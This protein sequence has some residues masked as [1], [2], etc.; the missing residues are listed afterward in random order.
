MTISFLYGMALEEDSRRWR[1]AKR[2]AA[3]PN[4]SATTIRET[5][6]LFYKLPVL[7]TPM[8]L[9]ADNENTRTDLMVKGLL[10]TMLKIMAMMTT[11]T[12]TMIVII[13]VI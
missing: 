9:F 2:A 4:K 12:T 5:P 11:R 1:L 7:F 6:I 13:L 3:F 10:M 8:M